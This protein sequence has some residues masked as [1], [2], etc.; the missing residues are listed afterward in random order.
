M[1]NFVQ[2]R[3][4]S[5]RNLRH[6]SGT[7]KFQNCLSSLPESIY[8]AKVVLNNIV[9][10]NRQSQKLKIKRKRFCNFMVLNSFFHA[11]TSLL[12]NGNY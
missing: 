6:Q 11:V 2:F 10:R 1:I 9:G 3:P 8:L 4:I 5:S 12:L 7:V